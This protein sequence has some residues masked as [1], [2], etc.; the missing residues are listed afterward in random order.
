MTKTLQDYL[1][2]FIRHGRPFE[3]IFMDFRSDIRIHVISAEAESSNASRDLMGDISIFRERILSTE[4]PMDF[5][6]NGAHFFSLVG[7]KSD[8]VQGVFAIRDLELSMDIAAEVLRNL[9]WYTDLRFK[10]MK[11]TDVPDSELMLTIDPGTASKEQ[12]ADLLVAFSEMYREMGGSGL[13]FTVEDVREMS[14]EVV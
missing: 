1:H 7:P 5:P 3:C 12:I 13:Q 9:G 6:A 10:D 8:S 11:T 4:E 2:T 14:S